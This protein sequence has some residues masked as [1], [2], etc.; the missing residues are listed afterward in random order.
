MVLAGLGY[1]ASADLA[2][3]PGDVHA[4][5]LRGLERA[6]S[7]HAAAQA[8]VLAAFCAQA[9]YETDGHGSPR[10]WLTWQTRISRQ[11]AC[12]AIASMRRL[13]EHAEIAQALASGTIS[14]SW[15][16]HITGW[17]S[18]LSGDARAGADQILLT[19]AAAGADLADLARLAEEMRR[20]LARPD[21]DDDG[22]DD[23][24]VRL[25][26]TLDGAGT[27]H[28]NLTSQCT[29]A[30]RAVLDALGKRNGPE[31][32]RSAVQ[33]RHD[34]L[35]EAC[36]RLLGPGCL[37]D[38]AGQPTQLQLHITLD[39][40]ANGAG[41][42]AARPGAVLPGPAAR[43][44]DDCD[45]AIAPVVTGTVDRDLLDQLATR[46]S[47][48]WRQYGRPALS[49][50]PPPC[51]CGRR[52]CPGTG[53]DHADQARAAHLR[54]AAARE[55]ILA[56]AVALLSGPDGLASWLRRRQHTGAAATISLPLDTGKVT[57]IIP[58][59]LRR[60]VT[61]RDQHCAAPG[62]DHPPAACQVHHIVP[63]SKGGRT[64]LTNLLLLCTF[65]HLI[66]V[67]RWGWHITLNP[68][69]TTTAT[70]PDGRVLH[71]H[72]PPDTAA[73]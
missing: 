37:P 41:P 25:G 46:L 71:S 40:L 66:L 36:R 20:R 26:T 30:L 51:P 69:G 17:T 64:R 15:A 29:A 4:G 65:H 7:M 33:R 34:A 24:A 52:H 57:E 59:H 48:I 43:P 2:S 1:L 50:E 3:A 70:S 21:R 11:A 67:H 9:G 63:R 32:T 28:G 12:A 68:D 8:R 23:R 10:T 44:G 53:C 19:A 35:E 5:C 18:R 56:N 13:A 22:F 27:L 6:G 60:A 73:A 16:D 38:R 42:A 61:A 54:W 49:A 58:A 31:D 72:S 62:C 47:D 55:L 14:R 39:E 45:A